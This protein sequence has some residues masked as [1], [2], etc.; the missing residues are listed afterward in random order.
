[1]ALSIMTLE[2][3][4]CPMCANPV[5]VALH[6]VQGVQNLDVDLADNVATI[7]YDDD[8]V[9]ASQIRHAVD[10]VNCTSHSALQ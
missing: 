1:M 5:S 2:G 4:T 10:D 8:E 3:A 6:A 9:T 7:T